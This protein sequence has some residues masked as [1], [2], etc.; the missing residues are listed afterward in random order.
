MLPSAIWIRSWDVIDELKRLEMFDNTI[1]VL[2][3]RSW[4][5]FGRS[6]LLD[7]AHEL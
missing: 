3:K 7:K 1:I 6:W 4:L 2:W 5:A